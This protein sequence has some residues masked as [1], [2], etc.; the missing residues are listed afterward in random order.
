MSEKPGSDAYGLTAT[1]SG[2]AAT[3]KE[4]PTAELHSGHRSSSIEGYSGEYW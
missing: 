2:A 1:D 4:R 3:R